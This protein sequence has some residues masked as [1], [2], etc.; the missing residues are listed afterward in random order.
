[1]DAELLEFNQV[2]IDS[3]RFSRHFEISIL[4][5]Y[6]FWCCPRHVRGTVASVVSRAP[7]C[8]DGTDSS[9]KSTLT[10]CKTLA[11][12]CVSNSHSFVKY[13]GLSAPW[14]NLHTNPNEP[15]DEATFASKLPF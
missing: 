12:Y 3:R 5:A 6:L 13:L 8:V 7:L 2:A 9:E 10:T 4:A 11:I 14:F 1:M 15:L